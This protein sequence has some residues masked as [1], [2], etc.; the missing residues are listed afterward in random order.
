MLW[1]YTCTVLT[2]V[3]WDRPFQWE[4]QDVFWKNDKYYLLIF[5]FFFFECVCV[6][7]FNEVLRPSWSIRVMS[8]GSVS[9]TTLLLGRLS[10]LSNYLVLCTLFRQKLTTALF[11][12]GEGRG[13]PKKI[14]RNQSQWLYP[15]PPDHESDVQATEP[16][17]PVHLLNLPKSITWVSIKVSIFLTF[18]ENMLCLVLF[19]H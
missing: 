9:L 5:F 14:F 15:Q 3:A 8:S 18:H 16:L 7:V 12:S 19:T 6:C 2:G 11:E 13:W 4:H 17:R 1:V 10:P